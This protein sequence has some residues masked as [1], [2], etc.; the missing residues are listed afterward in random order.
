MLRSRRKMLRARRSNRGSLAQI[1]RST[2][3]T[4]RCQRDED[5]KEA[6]DM[7]L[8]WFTS[9]ITTRHQESAFATEV[10]V[11]VGEQ[12]SSVDVDGDD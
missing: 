7:R 1:L 3:Q 12:I 9:Y 6:L 5:K 2:K 4:H 11:V 8:L 10:G